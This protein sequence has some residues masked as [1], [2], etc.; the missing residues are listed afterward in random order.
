MLSGEAL[1][2]AFILRVKVGALTQGEG[3]RLDSVRAERAQ[4]DPQ[5]SRPLDELQSVGFI[6]IDANAAE[7]PAIVVLA[8]LQIY[9]DD[10][11][12]QGTDDY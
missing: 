7:G 10:L 11:E 8:P 5:F 2:L 4:A 1:D 3:P 12:N 9:L 6:G